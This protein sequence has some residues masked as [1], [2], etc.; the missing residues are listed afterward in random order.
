MYL[1]KTLKIMKNI[2]IVLILTL[3]TTM[4]HSQSFNSGFLLN[5]TI[6]SQ[7]TY[8]NNSSSNATSETLDEMT[9]IISKYQNAIDNDKIK[10]SKEINWIDLAGKIEER[11]NYIIKE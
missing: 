8:F 2:L 10:K 5:D 9:Y 3:C 1:K 7:I 4:G 11:N 6:N